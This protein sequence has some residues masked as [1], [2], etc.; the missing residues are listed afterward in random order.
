MVTKCC[1]VYE[2]L[3]HD[4]FKN[5]NWS[6]TCLTASFRLSV[7]HWT[8]KSYAR[9]SISSRIPHHFSIFDPPFHTKFCTSMLVHIL[10]KPPPR[11]FYTLTMTVS[12][13]I[14][15]WQSSKTWQLF[16]FGFCGVIPKPKQLSSP[17]SLPN[18]MHLSVV[19]RHESAFVRFPA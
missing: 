13:L 8:R 9:R 12:E 16:C 10:G 15:S 6:Q 5:E 14:W 1:L 17:K 3:S 4:W 18:L 7:K 11:A 19:N 2:K